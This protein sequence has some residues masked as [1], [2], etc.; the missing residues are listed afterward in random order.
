MSVKPAPTI[1]RHWAAALL[2]SLTLCLMPAAPLR[3]DEPPAPAPAAAQGSDAFSQLEALLR[4]AP[5]RQVG[6]P[7]NE[8][9]D[10]V[11]RERFES[12]AAEQNAHLGEARI[13][14]AREAVAA[15]DKADA[16]FTASRDGQL[17]YSEAAEA[18]ES[19]LLVY[20]L[21]EE[22]GTLIAG[23]LVLAVVLLLVWRVQKRKAL[24]YG[25]A[26][27]VALSVGL[28]FLARYVD[29]P[30]ELA[31]QGKS[32]VQG[33]TNPG[34]EQLLDSAKQA[35]KADLTAS[36]ALDGMWQSG[37][38][39]WRTVAFIPGEA[40]L[41][42]GGKKVRVHV[43]APNLVEPAN[44]PAEG[45][46]GPLV[47]VGDG[48]PTELSGQKVEG[49]AVLMEFNSGR[50]WL[51]AVQ[52]GAKA[53]IILEPTPG[54]DTI[55]AE[56]AQKMAVAT[57]SVPRFYLKRD[58]LAQAFGEQWL[59]AVGAKPQI[60]LTQQ[61]SR[62]EPRKVAA[63]WLFIPG[64]TAAV[65]KPDD[66]AR[67]LVHIQTY[68]DS[69]SIVPELAPGAGSASNLVLMMRL[70]EGFRAH[71]PARPVL[72]S[73]VNDHTNA[74]L[75]E[76]NFDHAAF[77]TP[78]GVSA[79][80]DEIEAQ[81]AKERFIV[82][83]HGQGPSHDLIEKMRD[84]SPWVAGRNVK[85]KESLEDRFTQ[86]RN[87][88]RAEYNRITFKIN[89]NDRLSDVPLSPEKVAAMKEERVRHDARAQLFNS[90]LKLF[91]R[92]GARATLEDLSTDQLA[93]VTEAFANVHKAAQANARMLE[94]SRDA[95]LANMQLR[96]RLIRL[97]RTPEDVEPTKLAQAQLLRFRA[98]PALTA[99]TLDL[100]FG[101]DHVGFFHWDSLGGDADEANARDRVSRLART[102]IQLANNYAGSSGEPNLL[103]DT[104][105]M[106]G[107][108]PWSA[109]LGGS[110]AL[111]AKPLHAFLVPA[112]TLATVRDMRP[113]DFTPDDLP[114]RIDRKN[115]DAVMRF[116]EGYLPTLINAPELSE[117]KHAVGTATPLSTEVRLLKLDEFTVGVPKLNLPNCLMV[118]QPT[119]QTL[120]NNAPM[121]G[122]VRPWG[123][124]M[125]D[126]R[127]AAVV[128][129]SMW[130]GAGVSMFGYIKRGEEN[131]DYRTIF[132][133][134]DKGDGQKTFVST[135]SAGANVE[136]VS[137]SMVAV[138]AI[139]VDLF[140]LTEPLSLA[141]VPTL[142]LIDALQESLPQHYSSVGVESA[143]GTYIIPQ[144]KDGTASIFLQRDTRFKLRAGTGL[145]INATAENIQGK[146][147]PA[148]VGR[149]SNL[150]LT[151]ANDMWLLTDGRLKL[152]K[153]KGVKNDTATDFN[154]YAKQLI[155]AAA[156]AAEAGRNDQVLI[157]A[158]AA[159]GLS[160]QAYTR[161]LG[162]INDLIKAVVIF[163]ALVIPF[164]VFLTKLISPYTDVN[165]NLVFF[166][167]VFALMALLLRF[168]HPAFEVARTPEVVILAFVIMG[169]AGFVAS[170][171]IGR[172]NSL[173]TQ[174]VEASLQAESVEAPQG[175]LAGV[176]F[177]VGVNNMKRRRIR[178]TLTCVTVILVTFTMLSVISVG[179]DAEPTTVRTGQ[180]APYN[181]FLYASPGLG[182]LDP[183]QVARLRAHYEGE[184]QVIARAW[185]QRL[186]EFGEYLGYEMTPVDPVEG[187][188]VPALTAKVLVGVE[189]GEDGFIRK[190]P[191]TA[192]RWISSPSAPEML[193][194]VKGAELLGI[195]PQNFAG[196]RFSI[197]GRQ[198]E[199]VG[200][201]K[202][203]DLTQTRDLSE[204][205]LLPMLSAASQKGAGAAAAKEASSIDSS[206][207]SIFGPGVQLAR[208]IDV[209]FVTIGFARSLGTADYR[210]LCVKFDKTRA[211]EEGSIDAKALASKRAWS[212]AKDLIKFHYA[213]VFVGVQEPVNANEGSG[214]AA[215]KS[216]R[217]IEPGQY[218]MASSNATQVGGILKI[219]IP[220]I[221]AAT[222]ILNTMLGSVMERRREVG[223]YNA[224]GLNPGH[225]MMFFLAESFVF[226][227]VG[228]VAGYLIGQTLSLIVTRL[229]PGL[230]LNY[231]SL[232]VM[233]VI[234]LTIA[235]VLLSTVYPAMMAARAAV[236]SGQRRW[237]LPQPQGDQIHVH[238]PFCYDAERVLGVCAYLRDYMKQN[239]EASTGKFLA[240]LGTV[241]RVPM[242]GGVDETDRAYVMVFDIAPAPFDLGVNQTMEVYA[243]FDKRVKAHM[244][245]V[246]L[247]RMTGETSNWVTVNQPFLESLR[248]RLLGW[249]SQKA[250]THESY[251]REGEQLFAG[252]PDLP[253]TGV[254]SVGSAP[255]RQERA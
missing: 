103:T 60:T 170:V 189:P 44:L 193:L 252:A 151:S 110:M 133:A 25:A 171:L 53:V 47:Y 175:R 17:G 80:L 188:A 235:T 194:S 98:L 150:V 221:L 21:F 61:P 27:A 148:D 178:T 177:V 185:A 91:N 158:E 212:A 167:G 79:E 144:Q 58:A 182:A 30:A 199:L 13:A 250:A 113:Y 122:Q 8:K 196:R 12:V 100:G 226:G 132:Y 119:G 164:C 128:R 42:V 195:T 197:A 16:E 90:V 48:G 229:I 186:G 20:M 40:W 242:S 83:V 69:L 244:L 81:L 76:Q 251:Y 68:K 220:I 180:D 124:T 224:I 4:A 141:P 127:A 234:F 129:G 9:I 38:I 1:R 93:V 104:V 72:I 163:L 116:A 131:S 77:A 86:L 222:I 67:Q 73:V 134:G 156:S 207:G 14:A 206:S 241:G 254:E 117:I 3:A 31:K 146:G 92:Y 121:L 94:R 5:S 159:Q 70:I 140:G 2:A 236:P 215:S 120:S 152:L 36:Q 82:Q 37:R 218:A 142:Q 172:F 225:V 95:L 66:P 233:V 232:S 108:L 111:A 22:P 106:V 217:K 230:N 184:A 201:L 210:T 237:S 54:R 202:D 138:D 169:L 105:R 243:Y 62:W 115:F 107:G 6:Q 56:A 28:F 149:L 161:A 29:T 15:A 204:V 135:I 145:A 190:M 143:A 223:I 52:L 157:N 118:L 139:K 57:L 7:G 84:W 187:A 203:D 211:G 214:D 26:V 35:L 179:Q 97:S 245:S 154:K 65:D 219:A 23:L 78:A 238:F 71:P 165:R 123:V 88:A 125:T 39:E 130:R 249:R 240:K 59:D 64:P 45:F 50:R 166:T 176:A 168:V 213:R 153:E 198:V 11:V 46:T 41:S 162:T 87:E 246:H 160:Y 19:S 248:K 114:S 208:P 228:S 174:A 96:R 33:A 89:E 181:G 34:E 55:F 253:V 102:A 200:L 85:V 239:S 227:V 205:P 109:H 137:K 155:D 192:G 49:A 247:T 255:S 99:I 209:A 147:F 183:V 32:A 63:D 231:S 10:A 75:G 101:S 51:N 191:V 74:L 216:E 18:L 173:M 126:D 43:L 136:Y 24:G 112:L